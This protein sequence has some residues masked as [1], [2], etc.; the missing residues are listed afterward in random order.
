[1]V[2]KVYAVVTRSTCGS[3]FFWRSQTTFGSLHDENVHA[4]AARSTFRSENAQNTP[5]SE[6][7]WKC[8]ALWREAH[9]ETKMIKHHMP[10]PFLHVEASFLCGRRKGFGTLA[11]SEQNVK[12]L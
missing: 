8:A 4:V 11:T 10:G 12:A 5:C 7:F 3:A 1:V 2:E 9:F 6:H